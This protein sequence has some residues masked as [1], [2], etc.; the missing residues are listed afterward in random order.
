LVDEPQKK[1][2]QTLIERTCRIVMDVRVRVREITPESVADEFTP[3]DNLPWEWAERQ[4]RLL[5]ALLSDGKA[6]DQYL[7]YVAKDDLCALLDSEH[8]VGPSGE[9]VDDLL[10]G[11]Y[12]GMADEDAQFFREARGDGI[13]YDNTR[14]VDWAFVTEW[15]S[16]WLIDIGLVGREND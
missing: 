1:D 5:R 9:E 10:E 4:S 13:L 11:V 8:I 3:S 16:A 15:A 14:L 6:L 7:L 2:A 12:S